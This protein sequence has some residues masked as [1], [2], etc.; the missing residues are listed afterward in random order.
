MSQKILFKD[1]IGDKTL[2]LGIS[3]LMECY[4]KGHTGLSY[5]LHANPSLS[6]SSSWPSIFIVGLN[7]TVKSKEELRFH[8]QDQSSTSS[9]AVVKLKRYLFPVD[10]SLSSV[11][12]LYLEGFEKSF[13]ES[14]RLLS[15]SLE[16]VEL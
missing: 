7:A 9:L 1:G 14:V 3:S 15:P 6:D 13:P 2:E 11:R 4:L 8:L 16:S 10:V 12:H 5:T